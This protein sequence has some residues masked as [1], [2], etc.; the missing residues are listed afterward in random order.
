MTPPYRSV[1][2]DKPPTLGGLAAILLLRCSEASVPGPADASVEPP[3]DGRAAAACMAIFEGLPPREAASV[4]FRGELMPLFAERCNFGGCHLGEGPEGQLQL[5][6]TCVFDP[7]TSTCTAGD[8]GLA[9]DLA[10][11]L[12]ANLLVPSYA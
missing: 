9:A 5:G 6:L 12:H 8:A 1:Y 10:L 4:S 3:A 7:F 11:Q 2:V